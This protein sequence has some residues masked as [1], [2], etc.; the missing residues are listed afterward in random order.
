MQ[1]RWSP[2]AFVDLEQLFDYILTDDPAAAQRA[3]TAIYDRAATLAS[4][5]Y[6]GRQGRVGGTRDRRFRLS[7]SIA[8]WSARIQ[9]K[10]SISFTARSVGRRKASPEADYINFRRLKAATSA[11]VKSNHSPFLG[12]TPNRLRQY[13]SMP[14]DHQSEWNAP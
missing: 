14:T 10:S 4:H 6:L 3:A 12:F 13:A 8:F 1:I 9:S 7:W 2:A 5:P 11:L